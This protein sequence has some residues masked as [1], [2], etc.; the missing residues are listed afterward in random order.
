MLQR[1]Q[2][3]DTAKETMYKPQFLAT[4]VVAIFNMAAAYGTYSLIARMYQKRY[5]ATKTI[6]I[7]AGMKEIIIITRKKRMVHCRAYRLMKLPI[8]TNGIMIDVRAAMIMGTMEEESGF[9]FMGAFAFAFPAS[10][11]KSNDP[12][13][14]ARNT[15][16]AK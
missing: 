14:I 13:H 9:D 5:A 3:M 1:M 4:P 10:W 12:K 6:Q 8:E 2:A 11:S 16:T 7:E 15:T